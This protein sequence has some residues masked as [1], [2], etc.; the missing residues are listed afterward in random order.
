MPFATMVINGSKNAALLAIHIGAVSDP[1]LAAKYK[2]YREDM[3]AQVMEKNR[4][5]QET[6]QNM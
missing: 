5:L 4:K 3:A 2:A 1:A 6:V